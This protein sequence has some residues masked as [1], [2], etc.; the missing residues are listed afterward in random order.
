[1]KPVCCNARQNIPNLKSWYSLVA[2]LLQFLAALLT[3]M[4][5]VLIFDGDCGF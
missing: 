5:P 4:R 1:L 2:F 3:K